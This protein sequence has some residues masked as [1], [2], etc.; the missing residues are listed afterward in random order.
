MKTT[1]NVDVEKYAH[2]DEESVEILQ[3]SKRNAEKENISFKEA[4]LKVKEI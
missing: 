3:A 2:A 1:P 4:L